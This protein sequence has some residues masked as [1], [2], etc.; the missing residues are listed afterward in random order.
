MS[1]ATVVERDV[2]ISDELGALIELMR[3]A[4][5]RLSKK[6]GTFWELFCRIV[7]AA[8]RRL[9]IGDSRDIE[10]HIMLDAP[11]YNGRPAEEVDLPIS[12]HLEY[13]HGGELDVSLS[14]A[15]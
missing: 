9:K 11:E 6:V 12:L 2:F 14:E 5:A 3:S 1:S 8:V 7:K 4:E 15:A 10:L 13:T